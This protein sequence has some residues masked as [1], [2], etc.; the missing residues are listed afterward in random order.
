MTAQV[1]LDILNHAFFAVH[2]INLLILDECHAAIKDSPMKEVL[3]IINDSDGNTIAW[4]YS[5]SDQ[6]SII[7]VFRL[8]LTVLKRP[9]IL[10]LSAAL[11]KKKCK[12]HKVYGIIQDLSNSMNAVVKTPSNFELV[13]RY[14]Q[15]L[16]CYLPVRFKGV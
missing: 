2:Q 7:R 9:K 5:S 8:S 3:R 4:F 12:P 14:L 13:Y 15:S 11:I 1:F 10:G 6:L 16:S